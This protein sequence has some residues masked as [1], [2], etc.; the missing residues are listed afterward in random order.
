V[1]TILC[2]GAIKDATMGNLGTKHG[3]VVQ[4]AESSK[5]MG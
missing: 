5:A 3:A 2:G 4:Q 1:K